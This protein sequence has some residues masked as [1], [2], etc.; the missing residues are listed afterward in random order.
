MK[1]TWGFVLAQAISCNLGCISQS[2]TTLL[3][4]ARFIRIRSPFITINKHLFVA[5]F[6]VY[7]VT[8][9]TITV[10]GKYFLMAGIN[11]QAHLFLSDVC[12]YLNLIQ[13]FIGVIFAVLCISSLFKLKPSS[14][15]ELALKTYR[16]RRKG[17]ITILLINL[18]Y[19]VSLC[20]ASTAAITQYKHLRAINFTF[21]PVLTSAINPMIISA[22]NTGIR[23]RI[24]EMIRA[25][26]ERVR[27]GG[28]DVGSGPSYTPAETMMSAVLL[29]DKTRT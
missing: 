12:F 9:T 29:D 5:F 7:F 17:C 14:G 15:E 22:R 4:V 24:E 19:L 8:M 27:R 2:A 21:L 25:V 1:K 10:I 23:K 3:A 11:P 20:F 26:K 18:P 28:D 16:L 6:G 13:C